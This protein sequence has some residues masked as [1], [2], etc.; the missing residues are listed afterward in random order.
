[1]K[2]KAI[3]PVLRGRAGQEC[4]RRDEE[5]FCRE[6]HAQER[7]DFP[8]ESANHLSTSKIPNGEG[9]IWLPGPPRLVFSGMEICQSP[10]SDWARDKELTYATQPLRNRGLE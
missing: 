10:P 1:M 7:P 8:V 2:G 4:S 9:T 6:L 5:D 3:L